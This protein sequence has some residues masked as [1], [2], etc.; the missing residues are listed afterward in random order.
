MEDLAAA[1]KANKKLNEWL[2]HPDEFIKELG[3]IDEKTIKL[4]V[5]VD[6]HSEVTYV[7]KDLFERMSAID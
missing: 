2:S 6:Y 5:L 3:K 1:K 4:S 7:F